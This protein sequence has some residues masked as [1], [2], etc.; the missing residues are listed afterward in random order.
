MFTTGIVQKNFV[1]YSQ[2]FL[3]NFTFSTIVKIKMFTD[4]MSFSL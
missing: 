1:D 2:L 3:N 4:M